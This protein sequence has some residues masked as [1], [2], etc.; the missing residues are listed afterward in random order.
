M[1]VHE[2]IGQKRSP[3]EL[4]RILDAVNNEIEKHKKEHEK[5]G[6]TFTAITP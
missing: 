5:Q 6:K 3:A 2:V 4:K 1:A